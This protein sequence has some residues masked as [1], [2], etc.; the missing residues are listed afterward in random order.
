MRNSKVTSKKNIELNSLF[1]N[2]L[3]SKIVSI[4]LS[5]KELESKDINK[6]VNDFGVDYNLS[7]IQEHL[8]ELKNDNFVVT[9]RDGRS[10]FWKINTSNMFIKNMVQLM[11]APKA[12]L[13]QS[14]SVSRKTEEERIKEIRT[15]IFDL[16]QQTMGEFTP[17]DLILKVDG[18]RQRLNQILSKLCNDELY[19]N[20]YI[21]KKKR[22]VYFITLEGNKQKEWVLKKRNNDP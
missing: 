5:G 2:S 8:K 15:A 13:S 7:V 21:G 22:G 3:R 17:S 20:K 19:V 12:V 4:F 1:G 9:R 14:D 10:W 16:T 11:K 18:S 6:L